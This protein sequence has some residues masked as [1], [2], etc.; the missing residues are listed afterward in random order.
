MFISYL[1]NLLTSPKAGKSN[2]QTIFWFSLSLTFAAIYGILALQKALSGEYVVQDDARQ[3]VFWMRRF[4]DPELFP[5]DLIANYFQS[6]APAGYT[7]LYR[8]MAFGIDPLLLSK[9]LPTVL[10]LI[11]TGY[12]FGVCLQLL[13][14]PMTGFI[15][16][17]LLNQNLWMQDG[18]ISATP[19]AFIYPLFLAF[20][21]Y[22]L[23][24]SLLPCAIALA[25]LGLFY[26]SLVFICAVLLILQLGRWERGRLHFQ[27]RS[28]YIFCA[29]GLGVALL[30]LLPYAVGSSEFGPTIT[31]AEARTLP[32]FVAGKRSSF[33]T[34]T[35]L[36]GSGSTPV[37]Q[38]F[39]CHPP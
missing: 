2:A 28:A 39:D 17:L 16:A 5:H 30:V 20:L 9:L 12:C 14:V 11:T 27:D 22:L 21:Y 35:I 34:T 32:E 26:P 10:G 8:L 7:A 3:H 4:L 6:V 1:H 38:A 29:V 37:V 15:A 25:L 31:V 36:G 18:L 23:R 13:P 19:K 33:F 24:R